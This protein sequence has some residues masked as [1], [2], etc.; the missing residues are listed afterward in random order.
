MSYRV[1]YRAGSSVE[2]SVRYY[3]VFHSSEALED[4]YHTFHTGKI[5][6]EKI[7]IYKL[8]EHNRYT[9][10]WDDRLEKAVENFENHKCAHGEVTKDDILVEGNKIIL[11][12]K[13]T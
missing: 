3:N 4:I 13:K 8:Q 9:D 11:E 6:A 5:H 10:S 2:K 7:T 1:I 12:R